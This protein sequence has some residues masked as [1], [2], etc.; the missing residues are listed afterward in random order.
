M[1][2]PADP[3][4][5][6]LRTTLLWGV[7][8]V[9]SVGSAH[10]ESR[11][12]FPVSTGYDLYVHDYFLAEDDTTEVIQEF[13]VQA[14]ANGASTWGSRN[15][16]F[17]RA[18]L[19]GGTELYRQSLDAG[20]R[21]RT[22]QNHDWL[23]ADLLMLARQF[24]EDSQYSLSS[25]NVEVRLLAAASPWANDDV[26]VELRARGRFMEYANPST[27]EVS[28]QDGSAGAYVR[29]P[30][31][32]F[33]NWSLGALYAGRD[34]PDSNA[35]NR[36]GFIVEGDYDHGALTGEFR[37]FHRTERRNITDETARPSAWFHW[38]DLHSAIPAGE[39]E[40]VLRGSSEVWHYDQAAGAWY[41][42]WLVSGQA[43]GRWGDPLRARYELLL[44]GQHLD[45]GDE[46]ETH[47]QMGLR[48][49]AESL[50]GRLSGSTSIEVGHR[51]FRN[52]ITSVDQFVLNYSDYAYL[53]LW[54][55]A[56]WQISGHFSTDLSLN[57]QPENHS[58]SEDDITLGFA[59]LRLVW[60]P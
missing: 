12:D 3:T 60:R 37:A 14:Q 23:R 27:L 13:N 16:W 39:A 30:G 17:F 40:V 18:G 47:W 43:G 53:A 10:A 6:L 29:S 44:T 20:F 34:Y 1:I 38:T 26:A 7:V 49:G 45:A 8:C 50:A 22:R 46:P 9:C 2:S 59:S 24:R 54:L 56:N 5:T 32:S 48:F 4:R 58:R 31:G 21:L 28:Y 52:E 19:S 51:W 41:D 36:E 33:R 35:I 42:S 25:D 57:F 11:W 55:M 15:R